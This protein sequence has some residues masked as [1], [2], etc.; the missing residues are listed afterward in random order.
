M[1]LKTLHFLPAALLVA[2]AT[3]IAGSPISES[4]AVDATAR[5][6]ISNVRGSVTVSAWDQAR[7]EVTGT[8]GTGSKGLSIS[9][10]GSRL[11]I[12]VEG[13]EQSGWFNWG[14]NSRMEDSI[15]D[16]RVPREAELKIETVSAGISV[17]G[18]AG[19]QLDASSVSGKMRLDSTAKEVEAGSI[20]GTIELS[21][22][23][24]RV[25][26]D[27]VSGDI[28]LRSNRD[29]MKL[30]TV[31]GNIVATTDSYREFSGSSVSG[32][33]TLRG[34]PGT[35]AR[36][37]AETMSGDVSVDLP[38]NVSARINAETFSGR[39]RSDFGTVR[40]P[41]HGPGRSLDATIGDGNA[42]V[43]IETFSGDITI[44]RD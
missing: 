38:G 18:T 11:T 39:I 37:D 26:A 40:E 32:D 7:V 19:R 10:G 5:I 35:D 15:L 2:S 33:I 13:A 30:E 9:G 25:H 20:S 36:L 29:R 28:D 41:E 16:I 1:R 4:R 23:G 42:R 44:R 34:T 8:L 31:S 6:D 12:K 3:A 17:T 14:S 43:S 21:G 24:E 27:T 22:A